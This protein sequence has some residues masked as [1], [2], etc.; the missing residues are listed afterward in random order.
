MNGVYSEVGPALISGLINT[1]P[2][3]TSGRVQHP[4]PDHHKTDFRTAAAKMLPFPFAQSDRRGNLSKNGHNFS[5]NEL[6]D[7]LRNLKLK[8]GGTVDELNSRL[9]NY[10]RTQ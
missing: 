4:A 9:E 7:R 8:V 2:H 3:L 5:K 6:K 1:K 10:D